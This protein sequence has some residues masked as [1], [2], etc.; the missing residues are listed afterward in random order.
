[1]I[2]PVELA[3]AA[4]IIAQSSIFLARGHFPLR[5]MVRAI[6]H[7]VRDA[8]AIKMSGSLKTFWNEL[9]FQSS[10]SNMDPFSRDLSAT[11][12]YLTFVNYV[13]YAI[14]DEFRA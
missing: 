12:S 11:L 5:S 7:V 13:K 6:S 3:A 8:V 9:H 1:M 14:S 2:P 4:A 10:S